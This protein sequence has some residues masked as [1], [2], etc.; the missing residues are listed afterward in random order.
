MKYSC[1]N[2]NV[3]MVAEQVKRVRQPGRFYPAPNSFSAS[4]DRK[5]VAR[6]HLCDFRSA[7]FTNDAAKNSFDGGRRQWALVRLACTFDYFS[8]AL[9]VANLQATP[10]FQNSNL[11]RECG[12]PIQQVQQFRIN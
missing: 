8:F 12:A 11:K 1:R 6:F 3:E 5:R 2:E 4:F 9:R 7:R 10:M